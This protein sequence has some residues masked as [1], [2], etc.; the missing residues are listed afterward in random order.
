MRFIFFAAYAYVGFFI[1][2]LILD[3]KYYSGTNFFLKLVILFI[4]GAVIS[5]IESMYFSSKKEI[6]HDDNSSE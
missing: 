3:F 4:I 6:P 5:K 2:R 1:A